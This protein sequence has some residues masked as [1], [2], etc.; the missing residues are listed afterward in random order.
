VGLVHPEN[1]ASQRVLEKCGLRYEKKLQ[2]WG[3]DLLRYIVGSN[4]HLP[5]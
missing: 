4:A 1:F 3:M 5:S 2:M